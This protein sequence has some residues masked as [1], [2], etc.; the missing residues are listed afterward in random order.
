MRNLALGLVL[1][2]LIVAGLGYATGAIREKQRLDQL[3]A[4]RDA[5]AEQNRLD[6]LKY[7][8]QQRAI[9]VG[10]PTTKPGPGQRDA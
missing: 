4:E 1:F 2:G 8:R 6:F 7:E 5:A 3:T 10:R 9:P